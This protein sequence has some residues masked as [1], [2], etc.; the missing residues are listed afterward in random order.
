MQL[1]ELADLVSNPDLI[2]G[3]YNYCDRWCERCPFTAR[4]A[5]FAMSR[6]QTP[7]GA[8]DDRNSEEFWAALSAT[9]QNTLSLLQEA[10]AEQGIDLDDPALDATLAHQEALR[11]EAEQH[12]CAEQA[13]AYSRLGY[14]WFAA[15][16]DLFT[17]KGE[18]LTMLVR[19][20]TAAAQIE[21]QALAIGDAVAII[22]WYLDFIAVKLQRALQS[23]LEEAEEAEAEEAE[24][25][26]YPKDSA[27]SAKVALIA[28][29]RSIGAWGILLRHFPAQETAI[30]ERLAQLDRLRRAV[31]QQFP[32]ARQF[33]RPGFDTG[34]LPPTVSTT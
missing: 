12:P 34:D 6:A 25:D 8:I 7:A 33:I 23:Q 14:E 19:L 26:D 5:N 29:D 16:A 18:E 2:P 24:A 21:Q 3:I 22:Q 15:T 13:F 30:L 4:C 11:T 17:A 9:F 32:A 1:D 20:T 10:V 31:Q 28:I 27:G